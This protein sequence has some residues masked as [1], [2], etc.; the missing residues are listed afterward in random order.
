MKTLF[1]EDGGVTLIHGDYPEMLER[2]DSDLWIP[3]KV[4]CVV[5]DPPWDDAELAGV[6]IPKTKA[7]LVFTD[8]R[9]MG[10][11]IA[12]F[13]PPAWVFTWDTMN[14]WTT[15]PNR[16]IQQTK[17]CL[18]YGDLAEYRR[19]EALRGEAPPERDN[20]TT[21]QTPLDGRRLTDLWRESLR[22]LHN[23]D[24]GLHSGERGGVQGDRKG[25]DVLRH[26]KPIGWMTCL[27]ANC[28]QGLVFDPFCGTGASLRAA[29]DL[30]RPAVGIDINPDACEYALQLLAQESLLVGGVA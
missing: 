5:F 22:W 25:A 3:E 8:P 17:Q 18:F 1:E 9:R 12:R 15:G 16:P 20:P 23:P 28:S 14:Q 13:G 10:R 30:G 29:K 6:W 27:I 7:T 19:D 2:S 11:S 24:A 4:G 26:A 21:K